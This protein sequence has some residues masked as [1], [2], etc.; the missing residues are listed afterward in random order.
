MPTRRRQG[1]QRQRRTTSCR[2]TRRW[3]SWRWGHWDRPTFFTPKKGGGR[4]PASPRVLVER[5]LVAEGDQEDGGEESPERHAQ[6][7]A[8]H[9]DQYGGAPADR[10]VKGSILH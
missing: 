8:H 2:R 4:A 3:K 9:G 1:N 5:C 10:M 6:G 7:M